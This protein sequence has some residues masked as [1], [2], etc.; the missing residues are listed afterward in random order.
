MH[1]LKPSLS[2]ER[3]MTAFV[4]RHII[5]FCQNGM[6]FE[7]FLG[8]RRLTQRPNLPIDRVLSRQQVCK[9]LYLNSEM[10]TRNGILE[11][12][13]PSLV[14]RKVFIKAE[15]PGCQKEHSESAGKLDSDYLSLISLMAESWSNALK[16]LKS[17]SAD[18]IK[19]S[20]E[21]KETLGQITINTKARSLNVSIPT[22]EMSS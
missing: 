7:Y 12:R 22:T 2:W 3:H 16:T 10:A 11:I 13:I 19:M 14:K 6:F 15:N 4:L 1:R 17:N 8:W 9:A 18:C 5:S 21:K 20:A